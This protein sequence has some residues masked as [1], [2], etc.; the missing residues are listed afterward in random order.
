MSIKKMKKTNCGNYNADTLQLLVAQDDV[1]RRIENLRQEIGVS[2][3]GFATKDDYQ[4]WYT[5][6][7]N[8]FFDGSDKK[9]RLKTLYRVI[10]EILSAYGLT[11]DNF[12]PLWSY[13]CYG[14][15]EL[16]IDGNI[17]VRMHQRSRPNDPLLLEV[18]IFRQPTKKELD[19]LIKDVRDWAGRNLP[20]HRKG[21]TVPKVDIAT[22]LSTHAMMKKRG[23]TKQYDSVY[24]DTLKKQVEQGLIPSQQLAD[25]E[26][27]NKGA[28]KR[29]KTT[30]RTVAK[31][32][33]GTTK[34]S[35]R[36]RA[37]DKRLKKEVEKRFKKV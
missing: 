7:F 24:L 20:A 12:P 25:A 15:I 5:P 2:V 21:K 37:I 11:K 16:R 4:Q 18:E 22:D 23:I 19:E 29:K 26:K 17:E 33:F 36:V 35:A 13:I 9:H 8:S 32:I 31:D 34:A 10:N 14:K 6:V 30:S 3:G 28:V 27:L 1:A